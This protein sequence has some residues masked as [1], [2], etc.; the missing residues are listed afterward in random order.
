MKSIDEVIIHVIYG[1]LYNE[2]KVRFPKATVMRHTVPPGFFVTRTHPYNRG[3]KRLIIFSDVG[4]P[5]DA[6]IS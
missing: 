5:N 6:G 4:S 3:N 2:K 1:I